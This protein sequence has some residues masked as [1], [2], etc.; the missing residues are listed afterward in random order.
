MTCGNCWWLNGGPN[1]TAC[2]QQCTTYENSWDSDSCTK[3]L[4]AQ[5]IYQD[6]KLLAFLALVYLIPS[7]LSGQKV[8]VPYT[9][10]CSNGSETSLDQVNKEENRH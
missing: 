10:L 2:T 4:Q 6:N 5:Y 3:E 9:V 1:N 7:W 8:S